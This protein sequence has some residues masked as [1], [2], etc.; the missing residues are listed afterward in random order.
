[1][2]AVFDTATSVIG[3]TLEF[4]AGAMQ[5]GGKIAGSLLGKVLIPAGVATFLV[6][7][8]KEGSPIGEFKKSIVEA[9][10]VAKDN[11]KETMGKAVANG[12][13]NMVASVMDNSIKISDAVNNAVSDAKAE[14]EKTETTTASASSQDIKF[15]K[16]AGS[17]DASKEQ[18]SPSK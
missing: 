1:M 2:S 15:T 8:A 7:V 13:L 5:K 9:F 4:G 3:K 6:G 14:P 16:D 12:G 17:K 10:S 18:S 11:V